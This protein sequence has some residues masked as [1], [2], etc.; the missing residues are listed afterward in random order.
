MQGK[1]ALPAA[2][3]ALAL[4]TP[5]LSPSQLANINVVQQRNSKIRPKPL[6]EMI[7]RDDSGLKWSAEA[8]I[9]DDCSAAI[10]C[11]VVKEKVLKAKS[12]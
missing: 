8:N 7:L 2:R 12:T 6:N 5:L 4:H 10:C 1:A 11:L 3:A 9:A